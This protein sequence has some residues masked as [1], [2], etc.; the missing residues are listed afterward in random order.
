MRHPFW[1]LEAQL[2]RVEPYLPLPHEFRR[3]D[4]RNMLS[5]IV[6][7]NLQDLR[8]RDALTVYGPTWTLCN[9]FIR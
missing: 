6:F 3:V 7:V 9:R 5:G 1:L 8:W 4:D 2:S